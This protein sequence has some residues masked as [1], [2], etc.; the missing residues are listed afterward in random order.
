MH[1]CSLCWRQCVLAFVTWL[2]GSRPQETRVSVNAEACQRQVPALP[3]MPAVR[4]LGKDCKAHCQVWAIGRRHQLEFPAGGGSNGQA[5]LQ[6]CGLRLKHAVCAC[7]CTFCSYSVYRTCFLHSLH[8]YREMLLCSEIKFDMWRSS[9]CFKH[10]CLYFKCYQNKQTW[11][12]SSL[13]N[14][15]LTAEEIQLKV[16]KEFTSKD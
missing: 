16:L 7:A 11:T 10:S 3:P 14:L 6:S 1:V 15:N 13:L 5:S 4:Q 12:R 8:S 9:L 2:P